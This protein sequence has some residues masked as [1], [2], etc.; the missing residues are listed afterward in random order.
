[1]TNSPQPDNSETSEEECEDQKVNK[2]VVFIIVALSLLMTTVDTT[3]VA[4]ALETL[5]RELDTSVNWVG[6]TM[7]A[8]SLGFVLMLP[9][10]AKLTM[11]YGPRKVFFLSIA[12]FTLTSLFCGLAQNIE[13]LIILRVIQAIGAA[14]ITPSVTAIIV[15]HF[16]KSRDRAVSLFGSIFPIGV[17]IGPIF[18]GLIVTYWSWHWIFFVNVPIGI[19][20][21]LMSLYFIPYDIKRKLSGHTKMD[22]MGI[23]WLALGILA[24]MFAATYLGD[25]GTSVWSFTFISLLVLAAIGLIGFFKHIK[26]VKNPFIF[27]R[28]IYGKGFGTVNFINIL[29]GGTIQGVIALLPLYAANRYGLSALDSGTL[30]IAQGSASVL[31]STLTTVFLRRTGYKIPLYIGCSFILLGV[32]LLAFQPQWE[33]SPYYWLAGGAFLIGIG[34][35]IISPPARNAGLQLAP[36]ESATIA[37]LRSLCLQ[38]GSI[39]SIA[40]FTAV[41]AGS[42]IAGEAQASIYIVVAVVFLI[43]LPVISK[44]P[45]HKGSW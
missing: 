25:K 21:I 42:Q 41:I 32:A 6:W 13:L 12:V 23:G 8:Y 22:I 7:T 26:I 36:E 35:G 24:S 15:D 4:T 14:G 30:L 27:P 16:G 44:V 19:V 11:R 45:E 39:V 17:M 34:M 38:L 2:I 1:M 9:L 43:F 40:I 29:Y 20:I 37:A 5:Q 10:S 33:I 31:L 18:G 3:I 28:F